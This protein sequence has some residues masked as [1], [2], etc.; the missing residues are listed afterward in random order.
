MERRWVL[1]ENP[2]YTDIR[3]CN[4]ENDQPSPEVDTASMRLLLDAAKAQDEEEMDEEE[5]WDEV[6]PSD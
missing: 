3:G 2:M 6:S 5:M 1:M 4:K